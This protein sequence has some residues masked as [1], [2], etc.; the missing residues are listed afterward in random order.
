[1]I[2]FIGSVFSPYYASARRR[3]RPNPMNHCALNV[4]LYGPR[5][6]RWAMTERGGARVTREASALGIGPSALEWID[7]GLTLDIN[8][9][10]APLPRR[11]RGKIRL[12]PSALAEHSFLIDA[13]GRHRWTPYAPCA[14]IDVRLEE[15]RLRWSG[16]AYFDSNCGA[17]PLEEAFRSWTWSRASV[18]GGTVVLYDVAPRSNAPSSDVPGCALALRFGHDASAEAIDLPPVVQ[19]PATGWRV[20]RRTRADLGYAA[21]VVQTLEDAPFYS[22]SLLDTHLLGAVAPAIHESLDLNR[23]RARWVQCLLPFRMPRALA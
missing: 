21:R 7:D 5:A 19:L 2:A 16:I 11:V 10:C 22:R 13:S 12:Q 20:A 4:A 15:P 1:M 9:V 3:G 17:E 23:F 18:P 14:R 8:E 6:S